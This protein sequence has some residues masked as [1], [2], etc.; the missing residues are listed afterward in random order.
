MKHTIFV[1]LGLVAFSVAAC[2]TQITP[3]S[4]P[5][6]AAPNMPKPASE[7]CVERG[8]QSEIREEGGGQVGYCLFTD[9]SECEEWAY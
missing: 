2:S 4:N 7:F 6:E 1:V 9:G 8:Y 5:T 3:Q